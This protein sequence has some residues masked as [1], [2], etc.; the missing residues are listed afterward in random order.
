MIRKL[1]LKRSND[2]SKRKELVQGSNGV[3]RCLGNESAQTH[4]HTPTPEATSLRSE[5]AG[6]LNPRPV[7]PELLLILVSVLFS[8]LGWRYKLSLSPTCSWSLQVA[9]LAPTLISSVPG[10]NQGTALPTF[11]TFVQ[12]QLSVFILCSPPW[13]L[14]SPLGLRPNVLPC[15]ASSLHWRIRPFPL[16]P[17]FGCKQHQLTLNM[18]SPPTRAPSPMPVL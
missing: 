2:L 9:S 18:R 14:N 11:C 15:P 13:S 8:T 3:R 6:G 10:M 16:L 4:P 17:G 5:G 1:R 12:V 7:T